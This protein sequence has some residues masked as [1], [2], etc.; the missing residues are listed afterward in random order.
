MLQK[1]TWSMSNV[2][3]GMLAKDDVDRAVEYVNSKYELDIRNRT[4]QGDVVFLRQIVFYFLRN[5]FNGTLHRLS[6][7][8]S[9]N[10]RKYDHATIIHS[11]NS[12]ESDV[13]LGLLTDRLRLI[14][15]VCDEL[16]SLFEGNEYDEQSLYAYFLENK[17]NIK[18]YLQE[19]NKSVT[20]E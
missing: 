3:F 15:S 19:Q 11:C 4:R 5:R 10:G 18:K 12:I 7:Y 9:T 1:I 17:E 16:S 8:F 20:F 6:G 13:E 2:K 14:I